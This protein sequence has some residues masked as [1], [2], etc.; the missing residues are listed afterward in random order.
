MSHLQETNRVLSRVGAR[1]LGDQELRQV[2]G[3]FVVGGSLTG[4]CVY[5]PVACRVISGD[6]NKIPPACIGQ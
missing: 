4:A 2:A 3:G 5:D 6:C 1:L